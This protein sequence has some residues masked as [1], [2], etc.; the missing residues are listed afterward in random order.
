MHTYSIDTNERKN[1]LLILAVIS[2]IFSWGFHNILDYYLLSLPWWVENPSV[3]FFYGVLFTIFDK[4]FWKYLKRINFVKTPNLIG[5]WNGS[6]KSSFDNYSSETEAT[7]KIF[8]SW[9]TIKILMTT[10][11]SSSHSE[12]A[13]IEIDAPEEKNLS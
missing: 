8:Q 7:L 3:L 1:I 12:S 6:L 11:Q 13:A 4:S 5:E 2:I 10:N 9:T